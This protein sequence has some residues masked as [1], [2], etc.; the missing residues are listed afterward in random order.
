MSEEKQK[1]HQLELF[2]EH[3]PNRPY[4]SN[5]KGFQQIRG[6]AIAVLQKYIQHNQPTKKRWLVF[7]YD[8]R[9]GV[10]EHIQQESLPAPNLIASNP[11]NQ[12]AHLF[13]MLNSPVCDSVNARRHPLDMLAKIQHVLT[14]RLGAD[15][16]YAGHISKNVLSDAWEVKRSKRQAMT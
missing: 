4:C 9:G 15:A 13:Y 14:E 8:K 7:D 12:H 10:L 3:L 2:R 6:K 11:A 1:S 16:G 5:S